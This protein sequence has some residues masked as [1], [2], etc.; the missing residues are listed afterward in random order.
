MPPSCGGDRQWHCHA[1][2]NGAYRR[3]PQTGCREAWTAAGKGNAPTPGIHHRRER[4]ACERSLRPPRA[5]PSP[6][7]RYIHL[8]KAANDRA[9][10]RR[11]PRGSKWHGACAC[12][13]RRCSTATGCPADGLESSST[14][15]ESSP[16]NPESPLLQIPWRVAKCSD[17][18]GRCPYAVPPSVGKR[19]MPCRQKDCFDS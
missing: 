4:W 12:R 17:T 11:P 6:W 14:R 15:Q 13:W 1:C 7:C 2:R 18:H 5:S 10:H 9:Q 19:R 16:W 8:W 3:C